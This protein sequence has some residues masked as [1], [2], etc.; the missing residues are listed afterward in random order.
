MPSIIDREGRFRG[1]P[2]SWAIKKSSGGFPQFVVQLNA[3]E[4]WVEG[5]DGEPGA[6]E[7]WSDYGQS[8]IAYLVLYNAEKK[9]VNCEQVMKAFGWDGQSFAD[10]QNGDYSNLVVQ[11]QVEENTYNGKTSLQISWIDEHDAD[12]V[13]TLS[14]MDVNSLTQ[15]E[16][17][18]SHLMTPKTQAAP[19]KAPK[20]PKPKAKAKVKA[21]VSPPPA[22]PVTPVEDS[23]E[24][25]TTCSQDDAWE[26]LLKNKPKEKP[27]NLLVDAWLKGC[28][29]KADGRSES[30]FTDEDWAAIRDLVAETLEIIS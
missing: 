17:Q 2:D 21:P 13:R 15:L 27:D 1:T 29:F 18:F 24:R 22:A 4:I 10:L 7:D 6:W 5:Q 26:W 19:A 3:L 16:S 28:E 11:F 9:L 30:E 14:P 23:E 20:K 25:P 8:M 12:P